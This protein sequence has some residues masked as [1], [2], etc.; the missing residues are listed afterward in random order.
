[1]LV[2][3]LLAGKSRQLVTATPSMS[4]THAMALLIEHRISCLL[5]LGERGE[6]AGIVSDKD[7]FGLVHQSPDKFTNQLLGGIM[8]RKLITVNPSDDLFRTAELMTNHRIRHIPVLEDGKLA[9]LVSIGDVVKA[10]LG[11]MEEENH[12]LKK[13]ISGDYPA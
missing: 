1:M 12:Q 2:S 9:G 10:Q 13:Y 5:I 4:V 3:E 7:I 8:T 6:L 11:D